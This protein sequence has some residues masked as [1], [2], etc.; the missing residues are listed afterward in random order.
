M[1]TDERAIR[2]LVSNWLDASKR[3]DLDTVLDLMEDD[4]VF[5]PPGH[6]QTE[7]LPATISSSPRPAD[8]NYLGSS[9]CDT[10]GCCSCHPAV[11]LASRM[12][13]F[14]SQRSRSHIAY[15]TLDARAASC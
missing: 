9:R 12:A 1:K 3:G 8:F 7:C 5:M 15:R 4:A 10:S 2:E 13:A 6:E 14:G 11:G